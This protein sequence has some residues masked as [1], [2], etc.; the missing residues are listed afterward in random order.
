MTAVPTP[1]DPGAGA[2]LACVLLTGA[3]GALGQVLREPLRRRCLQAGGRLRLSDRVA[4]PGAPLQ[5]GEEFVECDLADR[6]GMHALLQGVSAVVHLGGVSVEGPFDPILQA[7]ILGV[8][9]LYEAARVHGVPRI[10]LASSNHATGCYEQGRVIT[11]A[12]PPRPDGYY[13]VSKLFAEHMAQMYHDRYGIQSVCLRIGTA[14]VRP[15]DRRGLSTWLSHPDLIQ[16]VLRSLL[17]P[18]VGCTVMY[19][20]SANQ[21]AW[22]RDIGQAARLG[23]APQDNSEAYRA[24]IEA[25]PAPDPA[26]A[27]ARLQGG[28]FLDVGPF[29]TFSTG[30]SAA[31]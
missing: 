12:D 25:R 19:G 29:D 2:A 6:T 21:A 15:P 18:D 31:S 26:S 14:T 4:L 3:S 22:W 11:A 10:V 28:I 7:N 16:L 23:Y 17:S 13:G 20:I 1:T 24:E 30:D 27:L 5:P 8:F 9:H